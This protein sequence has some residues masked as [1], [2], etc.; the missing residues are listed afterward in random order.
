MLYHILIMESDTTR[1]L[2]LA[3]SVTPQEAVDSREQLV[4]RFRKANIVIAM[5]AIGEGD[6]QAWQV[7]EAVSASDSIG[8][9]L[10]ATAEHRVH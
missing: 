6:Y 9:E 2:P 10:A 1:Q 3:E 8:S 4:E 7:K 5:N